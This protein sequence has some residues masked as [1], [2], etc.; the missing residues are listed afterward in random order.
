MNTRGVDYESEEGHEYSTR[1]KI[2]SRHIYLVQEKLFHEKKKRKLSWRCPFKE[3][4][5]YITYITI[6]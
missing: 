1:V 5:W 2:V 4:I 6:L 3:H